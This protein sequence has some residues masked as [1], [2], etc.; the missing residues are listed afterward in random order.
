MT[1]LISRTKTVTNDPTKFMAIV[2]AACNDNGS[3]DS[4]N[5]MI[6]PDD[7]VS[8]Q[9]WKY[10][11]DYA[12]SQ[13]RT[14]TINAVGDHVVVFSHSKVVPQTVRVLRSQPIVTCRQ[15]TFHVHN[16]LAVPR[17]ISVS[18]VRDQTHPEDGTASD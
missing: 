4:Y 10:I 18:Q 2:C 14:M 3:V 6:S 16:T 9:E 11:M 7:I 15:H 8:M 12:S 1:E 13:R 17:A 5:D